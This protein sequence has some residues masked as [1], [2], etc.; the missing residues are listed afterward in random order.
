MRVLISLGKIKRQRM[1]QSHQFQ[2]RTRMNPQIIIWSMP[3]FSLAILHVQT[4]SY[5]IWEVT[6]VDI[7]MYWWCVH[8]PKTSSSKYI[9][10][11]IGTK[12]AMTKGSIT[13]PTKI[14]KESFPHWKKSNEACHHERIFK[15]QFMPQMIQGIQSNRWCQN[16]ACNK[17]SVI[18]YPIKG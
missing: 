10:C 6:H 5:L 2:I 12:N 13:V 11:K 1:C 4:K 17:S 9:I 16:E 3:N 7:A 18:S 15:K 14:V 8:C